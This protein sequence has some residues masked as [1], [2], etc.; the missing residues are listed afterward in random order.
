MEAHIGA[1]LKGF[2]RLVKIEIR[3]YAPQG[4]IRGLALKHVRGLVPGAAARDRSLYR[5][6]RGNLD[7]KRLKNRRRINCER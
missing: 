1:R 3:D 5:G 2:V 7:L 4:V 6:T